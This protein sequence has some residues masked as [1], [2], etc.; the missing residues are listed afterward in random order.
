MTCI[1]YMTIIYREKKKGEGNH[2]VNKNEYA[3]LQ[4][5]YMVLY[6]NFKAEPKP[7]PIVM[8]RLLIQRKMRQD[9]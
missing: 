8:L 3:F 1:S 6:Q 4:T 7:F 5:T 2:L 9:P